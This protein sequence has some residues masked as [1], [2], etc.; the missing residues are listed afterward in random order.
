MS[1]AAFNDIQY[2]A[3]SGQVNLDQAQGIVECFV[4][5]IGNKDSVGDVCATGAFTKSLMRRKPRVVWGHNWND[6]IGKV[7]EIYEVPTSDPRLPSKMKAAGIGGL[8]AKVQFNLNSE[9]GREA[10]ANVAF[11]GE[12]QE[13]SIGYKTLRAQFDPN[14]QA[15]ILYEVELYEVSPVLHGANQLTGTISV[16]SDEKGGMMPM[17]ITPVGRPSDDETEMEEGIQ[18]KL[19]EEL[20]ARLGMPVK[21]LKTEDGMVYFSRTDSD[22]EDSKYK[23]RY[24]RGEDGIFMFGRPERF[25]MPKPM[26][27]QMPMG[28][29]QPGMPSRPMASAPGAPPVVVP[30]LVPGATPVSPPMVRF[31]YENEDTPSNATPTKPKLVDEERDLAEALI[32]ITKRYGKFNEDGTGVWAGYKPAAENTV[33]KIGVKCSN[34]VLYEGNGKCKIVAQEVEPEGKCRFAVIPDGVVSMGPVQ[35]ASFDAESNEE[36]VK[37]LEE[38]EQ[39]YPGEFISGIL[40]GTLKRRRKRRMG[41]KTVFMLSEYSEKSLEDF[42]DFE[43]EAPSYVLPVSADKAFEVKQLIDPIIDFHRVDAYVEDGG[44]VFTN[45]VTRDFVEAVGAAVNS[46]FFSQSEKALGRNLAGKF[47]RGRG[48]AARFDPY[49]WDGDN[50][51]IVQ[52]GTAFERPAIPGLNDFASR[53]RINLAAARKIQ[54]QWNAAKPQQDAKPDQVDSP[55]ID[56]TPDKGQSDLINALS[57]GKASNPTARKLDEI[58]DA[59][60]DKWDLDKTDRDFSEYLADLDPD[61]LADALT[62]ITQQQRLNEFAATNAGVLEDDV[63]NDDFGSIVN[64]LMAD[65]DMDEFDAEEEGARILDAYD[66]YRRRKEHYATALKTVKRAMRGS[67]QLRTRPA[68]TR[69]GSELTPQRAGL[70]SG[71]VETP[72]QANDRDIFER[73]SIFGES[74]EDVAESFG[75]TRQQARQAEMRHMSRL[76]N[77]EGDEFNAEVYR[78]RQEAY[79]L[80]DAANAFGKTRE[81][82]R[83]A[84]MRHMSSLRN[85]PQGEKDA[86]IYRDRT[87]NDINGRQMSIA[88]VASKYGVS[89]DEA[90]RAELREARRLGD[91]LKRSRREMRRERVSSGSRAAQGGEAVPPRFSKSVFDKYD[92]ERKGLLSGKESDWV[93]PTDGLPL[94]MTNWTDDDWDTYYSREMIQRERISSRPL[95]ED[96]GLGYG[97]REDL[98][99]T[100][101]RKSWF[102]YTSDFGAAS[103]YE[104]EDGK[105]T[106]VRWEFDDYKGYYADEPYYEFQYQKEGFESPEEAADWLS[107]EIDGEGG[108]PF[109]YGSDRDAWSKVKSPE[110]AKKYYQRIVETGDSDREKGWADY[111]ANQ[112]PDGISMRSGLSSGK[113]PYTAGQRITRQINKKRPPRTDYDY[114]GDGKYLPTE[115]QMTAIDAV[116]TGENVVIPA[117]AGSGKTSTLVSLAKRM[118]KEQPDK[119]LVYLA[120]NRSAANDAER[121]FRGIPNVQVMTLD[122]VGRRWM[123]QRRNGKSFIDRIGSEDVKAGKEL[124]AKNLAKEFKLNTEV[125]QG[126][127]VSGDQIASLA[128]NAVEKFEISGD[129]SIGLQHFVDDKDQ[130]IPADQLPSNVFDVANRLWNDKTSEDGEFLISYNTLTKMWQSSNPDFASAGTGPDGAKDLVL[131]DESQDLNPVWNKAASGMSIQRVYVGD[132]NQAI[133]GFRGAVNE[134][135]SI[136]EK[137]PYVLPL[138]EVFRFGPEIASVGNRVLSLLGI[139]S[140]RMVGRGGKGSVADPG[141]MEN[142]DL[143]IA[144]TNGGVIRSALEMIDNGKSIGTTQRAKKELDQMINSISRL[145]FNNPTGQD[146]PDLAEFT[147]F[148]D[149]KKAVEEKVANRKQMTLYRLMTE[150]SLTDLRRVQ[151]GMQIWDPSDDGE[152]A[153]DSEIVDLALSAAKDDPKIGDMIRSIA[154]QFG[155]RELSPKQWAVLERASGKKREGGQPVMGL[156]ISRPSRV[157]PGASGKLTSNIDYN[158]VGDRIELSGRGTMGAKEQIKAAGFRWDGTKKVWHTPSSRADEA[159]DQLSGGGGAGSKKAEKPDVVI[160][161][162]HL[163]KG[164][165]MDNVKLAND[166]WGPERDEETGETVWPD[167]EHMHAVYVALTRAKKNLDPGGADWVFDW[168]D[169]SDGEPNTSREFGLSS[170]KKAAKKMQRRPWTEE[171]R[172]AFADGQRL[173]AQ[174]IQGKRR[175]SAPDDMRDAGRAGGRRERRG[176][177]SGKKKPSEQQLMERAERERRLE[178]GTTDV[179]RSFSAADRSKEKLAESARLPQGEEI[180]AANTG[181]SDTGETSAPMTRRGVSGGVRLGAGERVARRELG[182][183]SVDKDGNEKFTPEGDIKD[184]IRDGKKKRS[185]KI[186]NMSSNDTRSPGDQWMIDASKLREVFKDSLGKQLSDEMI[187]D[188]LGISVDDVKKWDAPGAAVA[189]T[190]VSDMVEKAKGVENLEQLI[191]NEVIKV[192]GFDSAPAWID[193]ET[194]EKITRTEF[195][196]RRSGGSL[197]GIQPY[198]EYDIVPEDEFA[199]AKTPEQL[200]SERA[201][202]EASKRSNYPATTL[203]RSLGVIGESDNLDSSNADAFIEKLRELG[204]EAQPKTIKETWFSGGIPLETLRQLE[205]DGHISIPDVYRVNPSANTVAKIDAT[206]S[207][208]DALEKAGLDDTKIGRIIN[209]WTGTRNPTALKKHREAMAKGGKARSGEGGSIGR[210]ELQ[211]RIDEANKIIKENGFDVPELSVESIMGKP[212]ASVSVNE[213]AAKEA[214]PPTF[215][216]IPRDQR[217]NYSFGNLSDTQI[218]EQAAARRYYIRQ[219]EKAESEVDS[220]QKRKEIRARRGRYQSELNALEVAASKRLASKRTRPSRSESEK[221]LKRLDTFSFK[222]E[223]TKENMQGRTKGARAASKKRLVSP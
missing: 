20:S 17:V 44:I 47:Q 65:F 77:M 110:E 166:F 70:S 88:E 211:Q 190:E 66:E 219:L 151:K 3:S 34:C 73:R 43:S 128:I 56:A 60:D 195:E 6:P 217:G 1:S 118:A 140:N 16:K 203:A 206:Q 64:R 176:L 15:N 52:E 83:Q 145:R 45:G 146:H 179:S 180:E 94:S 105:F 30:N 121:R 149:L 12:E 114:S 210:E 33:A 78:L 62:E 32:K 80:E 112:Y 92:E 167:E 147:S 137:E 142:P 41:T 11:F 50:D 183:I 122:S 125:V 23:C 28:R 8:Y 130:Q 104:T 98:S 7:I 71:R 79:S 63:R 27:M 171:E 188:L 109:I 100:W 89:E 2:K 113:G 138:T 82:I 198:T 216:P 119:K 212:E 123:S 172:Q 165:E 181:F 51:G 76:R 35:K 213:P 196:S 5:G 61:E 55:R 31:N 208:V 14:I 141:S 205:R 40:R 87:Q 201:I 101:D 106:A 186:G 202:R 53:G 102:A 169:D 18:R 144:R 153:K 192:W 160:L 39:K 29:P 177:S 163:S 174:T 199:N 139:D 132:P 159:F 9:K 150:I 46:A 103:V 84:E 135:D 115:E 67:G 197:F 154:S 129:D 58:I 187:A 136:S 72:S 24:H 37:W 90:R 49:A 220:P 157:S 204:V 85:L 207:V 156:D 143:I 178:T 221:S 134:L 127:E 25:M 75:M 97:F 95:G 164:L 21:V 223:I 184:R 108:R 81:E 59:H 19:E 161:T 200:R 215:V 218:V 124:T 191:P 222:S 182:R 209:Y 54:G 13:W 133:Y 194:G 68:K 36:E 26:P 38:I 86:A 162:S 10:F 168:T 4:A 214:T 193:N 107:N 116:M 42:I 91:D 131:F 69:E 155:K 126:R 148:D 189:E 111:Y 117:L 158:V 152:T 74:L 99:G 170:G 96:L 48:L 22:G 185:I 173:R 175:G 57:S 120:F 93:D